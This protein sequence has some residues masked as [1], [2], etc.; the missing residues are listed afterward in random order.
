VF[1]EEP[2]PPRKRVIQYTGQR[3]SEREAMR[4]SATM[5]LAGKAE[6]VYPVRL[7]ARSKLD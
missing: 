1:T 5:F 2:I 7:N 3:I 6:R 4:R